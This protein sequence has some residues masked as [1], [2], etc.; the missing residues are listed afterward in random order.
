MQTYTLTL[1]KAHFNTTT[2]LSTVAIVLSH[3]TYDNHTRAEQQSKHAALSTQSTHII[4][5]FSF[6]YSLVLA[7]SLAPPLCPPPRE[8]QCRRCLLH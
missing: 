3:A 8:A 2:F 7:L 6:F 5:K 1:F 4:S